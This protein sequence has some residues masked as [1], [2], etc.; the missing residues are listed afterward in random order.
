MAFKVFQ[1]S[2]NEFQ[3]KKG[4]Y[5]YQGRRLLSERSLQLA[6]KKG[7]GDFKDDYLKYY[8]FAKEHWKI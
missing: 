8:Y 7:Q 2:A 5:I 6:S 4:M 1:C 3:S